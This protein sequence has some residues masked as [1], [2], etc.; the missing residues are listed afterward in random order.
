MEGSSLQ[1]SQHCADLLR[2]S[3]HL[4]G[5]VPP[6]LFN[7][8]SPNHKSPNVLSANQCTHLKD[9]NNNSCSSV[10]TGLLQGS[11]SPSVVPRTAAAAAAAPG[12]LFVMQICQ[13]YPDLQ[14]QKLWAVGKQSVFAQ[15]PQ[16]IPTPSE[17]REAL[18]SSEEIMIVKGACRLQR[19]HPRLE[20]HS[21]TERLGTAVSPRFP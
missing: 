7:T 3:V 17:I 1:K 13:P 11:G 6:V 21:P 9:G 8:L 19:Q 5:Q 18:L 15:V 10:P 14:N 20:N 4:W 16:V 2:S 12:K